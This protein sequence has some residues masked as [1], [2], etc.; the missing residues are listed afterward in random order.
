MVWGVLQSILDVLLAFVAP[1]FDG[2]PPRPERRFGA[3]WGGLGRFGNG[4]VAVEDV[5]FVVWGWFGVLCN[6]F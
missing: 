2:R 1:K 3:V 5:F 6:F 4:L